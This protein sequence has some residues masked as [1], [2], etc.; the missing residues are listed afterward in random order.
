MEWK[1]VFSAILSKLTVSHDRMCIG[2]WFHASGPATA[3]ARVLKYYV[4][5]SYNLYQYNYCTC[6]D[7]NQRQYR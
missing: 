2:S 5:S 1:C 6:L 7:V 3:N 4:D